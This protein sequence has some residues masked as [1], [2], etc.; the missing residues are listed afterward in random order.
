M[1]ITFTE[2]D[3]ALIRYTAGKRQA[4]KDRC[5]IVDGKLRDDAGSDVH[6]IGFA[7]ELAL[8]RFLGVQPDLTIGPRGHRG[9]SV[10]YGQKSLNTHYN[11][12]DHG[13]LRYFP[14]KVPD[15]DALVLVIGALP[16]LR[17][18]GWVSRAEFDRT[19]IVQSLPGMG[20]RWLFAQRMLAPMNTL[21]PWLDGETDDPRPAVAELVVVRDEERPIVQLG[22]CF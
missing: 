8:A 21:R 14:D 10:R 20:E 18:V 2:D 3:L 7:A 11:S 15:V 5:G 22:L 1:V 9:K 17:L 6:L 19:C 13:D 4:S 16:T 12:R